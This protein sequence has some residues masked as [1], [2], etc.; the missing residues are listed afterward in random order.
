MRVIIMQGF[1]G[2]GKSTWAEHH[3]DG[4]YGGPIATI[5]SADHYFVDHITGEYRFNPAHLGEA[6]A[7]CMRSFLSACED[8]SSASVII[9]DNT[10]ITID[11]MAPYYLVA[12]A[13]K[14]DVEVVRV[15]C[16]PK[17]AAARNSHGV[18]RETV[19]RMARTMQDPPKFWDCTF[20]KVVTGV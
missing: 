8:A 12:R 13:Y 19:L 17:V 6:H 18:P 10:N 5:V 2:S 3:F 15:T 7:R 9:V 1:P 16:D 11:Q 20:T 4:S 14:A